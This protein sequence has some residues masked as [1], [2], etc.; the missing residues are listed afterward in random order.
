MDSMETK[1]ELI[2][3]LEEKQRRIEYGGHLT[4]F[5]LDEGPLRAEL[6]TKHIVFFE[7][8]QDYKERLFMA[9]N[10]VG[11]TVAGAYEMVCHLTGMYPSWWT[12]KR[13]NHPIDAWCAGDT[14]QTTR[15][16]LQETLIGAERGTGMIPAN[17]LGKM[18][19]RSGIPNALDTVKVK[20]VSGGWSTLGFK[21][22]DQ[23]RRSFQ[24]TG[25]HVIWFDEE[26]PQAVY[27]EAIVRTMTTE[28]IIY[29]TFTPLQGLTKFIQDFRKASMDEDIEINSKL[30]VTAGWDDVPHLSEAMK[31]DILAGTPV[32]LQ[33]SRSTGRPGL[34]AGAIYT[35]PT[36]EVTCD[37]FTIPPWFRRGYG[38]DVGWNCTAAVFFAH[39]LDRD[40]VYI[41]DVY[42][43]GQVEPDIH[44]SAIKRRYIGGKP[45][46]GVIDPAARGRGQADG[47]NLLQ[48][49]RR[50]G[51]Q[52]RPADNAVSAGIDDVHMRLSSG[53]LKVFRGLSDWFDEYALYRRNE[54]GRIV[55]EDDHLMDATR[56]AIRSG[57]KM[58]REPH[59]KPV[60]GGQGKRYF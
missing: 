20:H 37:M 5:F 16:I 49:Y 27:G 28:G 10:R 55:K 32:H 31:R 44:T 45:L 9:A 18:V 47:K 38:L 50:E 36:K 56:Y 13:F 23:G 4:K 58:A 11:K 52:V 51:L 21:S 53:K 39:D 25:K 12:G 43:R 22:Y 2:K 60:L 17:L 7:G 30:T 48:I 34:G 42:K 57:L 33:E 46:V 3:L 15:D 14:G 24:G 8:G 54:D 40:I 1:L 41:Y 6:Y 59:V 29:V 35:V 19:N 26:C